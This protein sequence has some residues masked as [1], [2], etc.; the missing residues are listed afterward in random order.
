V[1]TIDSREGDVWLLCSDGLTRE[2][3]NDVIHDVLTR[4]REKPTKEIVHALIEKALQNG[5]RDNVTVI[6]AKTQHQQPAV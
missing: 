5:G 6:I 1:I 2:V 3:E 4:M